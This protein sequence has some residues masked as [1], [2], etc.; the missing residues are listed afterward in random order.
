MGEERA[1]ASWLTGEVR[2]DP[3]LLRDAHRV[4][5][6][7]GGG[8]DGYLAARR[9]LDER[10]RQMVHW[11][12][13]REYALL[14]DDLA[15]EGRQDDA[16]LLRQIAATD[17]LLTEAQTRWNARYATR[18]QTAGERDT[19]R[20][21]D[22]G[23]IDFDPD[24]PYRGIDGSDYWPGYTSLE[25]GHQQ[26][27]VVLV[28]GR[29]L[30]QLVT[31]F[32]DQAAVARWLHDRGPMASGPLTPPEVPTL[33][34]AVLEEHILAR[35]LCRPGDLPAAMTSLP[36]TTF[37]ADARY[38]IYAAILTVAS[39]GQPWDLQHVAA[40]L[41]HRMDWVPDWTLPRHGGQ[42]APWAQT[43]L[44]RLASTEPLS[45]A[46]SR[47]IAD[48]TQAQLRRGERG[49]APQR[50]AGRVRHSP[51][52]PGDDRPR[53]RSCIQ[54][55]TTAQTWRPPHGPGPAGPAPRL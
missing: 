10:L 4:F 8:E 33:P 14:A 9:L 32:D 22:A 7:R 11:P 27:P 6:D 43:Y 1:P 50:P 52:M 53:H 28:A 37:T 40:E 15:A 26:V 12:T 36:P 39:S 5:A 19:R 55:E 18:A 24:G 51:M 20:L 41:G 3:F 16:A 17:H 42:G 30:W 13:G 49:A 38:D 25:T 54:A 2:M 44:R 45:Y 21:I 31:G 47:L 29:G 23:L 34:R 35:M 48:D 46:V